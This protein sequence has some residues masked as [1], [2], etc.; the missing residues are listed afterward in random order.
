[1]NE[2]GNQD[3]LDSKATHKALKISAC[4]LSHIREAGKLRFQKRGNA[5]LYSR[6]EVQ[7]LANRLGSAG[8]EV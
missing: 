7:V 8:S 6:K 3:W 1:M 2:N 5:F 4:E